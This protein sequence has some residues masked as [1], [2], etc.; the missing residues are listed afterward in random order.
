MSYF[1]RTSNSFRVAPEEALDLHNLLPTGNYTVKQDQITG[2]FFLEML[3]AFPKTGKLYGDLNKK[4]ERIL[5]TFMDRPNSTG[6]M[7][8]GEKG[9]GKTLLAKLISQKA[10]SIG[11]PTIIINTAF[12]GDLFNKFLQD[13]EQP[14]IILFDEFEK[15][16]HEEEQEKILT[17][18]DGV[19]PSKKLFLLTCNDKW[20]INQH[21]RNRP[22]RIFYMID[23]K[24]LSSDFIIE[25]CHDVLI[26]KSHIDRIVSIASLFE[27][28]NFDMLKALVEEMNRYDES[29]Q[30]ALGVLNVKPEFNNRGHFDVKL[31]DN[32]IEMTHGIAKNGWEGNPLAQTVEIHYESDQ[33]DDDCDWDYATFTPNNLHKVDAQEGSFT[34]LNDN[35]QMCILTRKKEQPSY[36]YMVV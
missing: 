23:F 10:T 24:G 18:L 28:F 3:D 11:I 15:V 17:L 12:S 35:N 19:F 31:F 4:A 7:L 36:N 14:T 8:N 20:R 29:P 26:N 13:I 9:S 1:I 5:N 30:D 25:Y 2:Q 32:G 16:Y 33:E 27:Q 22:G 21:M 34:Y 6:V